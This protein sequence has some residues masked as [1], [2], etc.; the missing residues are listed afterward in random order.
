MIEIVAAVLLV[1]CISAISATSAAFAADGKAAKPGVQADGTTCA[2]GVAKS[3]S[4]A[5]R[6]AAIRRQCGGKFY[7]NTCGDRMLSGV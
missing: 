2:F 1:F 7:A 3:A 5:T 4:P 6:C